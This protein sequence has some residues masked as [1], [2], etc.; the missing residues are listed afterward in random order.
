MPLKGNW[1]QPFA[2]AL[3]AVQGSI[4]ETLKLS[5]LQILQHARADS[6]IYGATKLYPKKKGS[7]KWALFLETGEMN[8]YTRPSGKNAKPRR[9]FNQTRFVSRHGDLAKAFTPAGSWSGDTLRTRGEGEAKVVVNGDKTYAVLKFT[10]KAEGALRGG[11]SK[12]SRSKV[13]VMDENG[14]VIATQTE[15]GRRRPIETGAAKVSRFVA[16]ILKTNL[17]K[18]TRSVS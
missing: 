8:R 7:G 17:D 15:R 2:D 5:A 13:D 14:S 1:K 11:D 9:V 12:L 10:G 3:K 4:S 18:K 16:K 6:I